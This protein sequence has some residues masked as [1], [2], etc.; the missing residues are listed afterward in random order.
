[1][2]VCVAVLHVDVSACT[3][4]CLRCPPVN[5]NAAILDL[6]ALLVAIFLANDFWPEFTGVPTEPELS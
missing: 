6:L 1:M 2:L 3:P 4:A 5:R